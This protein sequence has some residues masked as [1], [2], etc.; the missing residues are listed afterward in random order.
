MADHDIAY[1]ETIKALAEQLK[2]KADSLIKFCENSRPF[3]EQ[4]GIF[5]GDD[6]TA[7]TIRADQIGNVIRLTE[8]NLDRI[9]NMHS[10]WLGARAERIAREILSELAKTDALVTRLAANFPTEPKAWTGT[11]SE[12]LAFLLSKM[13]A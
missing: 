9:K 12:R 4:V 8:E 11:V 1:T 13:N 7:I 10:M 6:H 2:D 3:A 5:S